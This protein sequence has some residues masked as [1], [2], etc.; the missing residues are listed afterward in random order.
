MPLSDEQTRLLKTNGN[1]ISFKTENPKKPGSKAWERYEKHKT[2]QTIGDAVALG[3]QWQDLRADFD[4][5]FLRFSDA[6]MP[7]ASKRAAP[8]GAP[9]REAQ[10]RAKHKPS[11]AVAPLAMIMQPQ[12]STPMASSQVEMS[13]ATMQTLR[14]MMREELHELERSCRAGLMLLCPNYIQNCLMS[15]QLVLS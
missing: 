12:A 11:Q 10:N 9:D 4:K 7:P 15:G 2:A 14:A 13:A 3:A 1:A 8:D 5:K 6:D